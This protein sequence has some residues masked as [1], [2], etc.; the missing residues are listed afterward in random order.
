MLTYLHI[1][2][3]AVIER[4]DIEMRKGLT[5]LTGETGAGKSIIVDAISFV[6][7]GRGSRD[8]IRTGA[9]RARVSA[10]FDG[11]DK[12]VC[13]LLKQIQAE[14]EDG[15]ILLQRDLSADGRNSVRINGVPAPLAMLREIGSRL[16]NIHGQHENQSLLDPR[17]HLGYLDLYGKA[18]KE[19]EQ[20]KVIYEKAVALRRQIKD[21]REN[22]EKKLHE[23]DLLKYRINE[24]EQAAITEGELEE[25]T[26]L[27]KKLRNMEKLTAALSGAEAVLQQ[28]GTVSAV[29]TALSLMNNAKEL[30]PELEQLW[31]RLSTAYYELQDISGEISSQLYSL[32]SGENIDNVGDRLDEIKKI[33]RKYGGSYE[34][35][36]AQLAE[37]KEEAERIELVSENVAEAEQM[38]SQLTK[39]LLEKAETLSEKR[40]AISNELS[41]R[42]NAELHFLAMEKAQFSV[43]LKRKVNAKGGVLFGADGIDEC[44]FMI[45]TNSGESVKPLAKTASGGEL[46]R[47]MLSIKNILAESDTVGTLIF[48]EVD[49][50]VSG[51]A[52]KKLAEKLQ[53]VSK[54]RQVICVTHLPQIAAYAA[55][56]LVVVKGEKEG[57]TFTSASLLDGAQRAEEIARIITGG[58]ITKAALENAEEMINGA[59]AERTGKK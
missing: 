52:G 28:D 40:K 35:V 12:A 56:H 27:E 19:L 46:S 10:E 54:N 22:E 1:E 24:I 8:I 49:S 59:N 33:Y 31:E 43:S 20:Y 44:E 13:E 58:A 16:I 15:T 36:M 21:F 17:A 48:D 7:G 45:A 53:Q 4:A 42:I 50:G 25:L 30:L 3:V 37:A 32:D 23:L 39:E 6:T 55:N 47:I 5:V 2:N 9:S 29:G 51:K 11:G 14:N 38:L 34:A 41:E 57:R 18:E 26:A